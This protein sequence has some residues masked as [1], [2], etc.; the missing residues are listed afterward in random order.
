MLGTGFSD[1]HNFIAVQV[2]CARPLSIETVE[3]LRILTSNFFLS[4]LQD[5]NW[6]IER[7]TNVNTAPVHLSIK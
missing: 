2:K 6:D 3:V 7:N 1:V 5:I 4:D